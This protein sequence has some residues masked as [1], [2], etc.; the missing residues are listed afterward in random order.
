M[1]IPVTILLLEDSL[2]DAELVTEHLDKSGIT[3]QVRRVETRVDYVRELEQCCP[4]VILSDFSLP[5]FDGPSAFALAQEMCPQVPFLF[6]SGVM[7]EEVAIDSLKRGATDYVLK[8]RLERLGPAVKRALRECRERNQRERAEE[9]LQ[10]NEERLRIALD[11]ARLGAWELD[12][13]T[14]DM[15][16]SPTCM[17]TLG[18]GGEGYL[19]LSRLLAR[20]HPE[21]RDIVSRRTS[22]A[23]DDGEAC[24]V[25]FRIQ[26]HDGTWR[27][28][29]LSGRLVSAG[30]P[31]QRRLAGVVR[32]ITQR[33]QAE[34]D[35][36]NLNR[37][38]EQFI[39]AASHDLRE[40]LRTVRTFTQ[41][42]GRE[43]RT[44]MQPRCNEYL[45][46]VESGAHRMEKLLH[47]L[48]DYSRLREVPVPPSAVDLNLVLREVLMLSQVVIEETN[49]RIHAEPLPVVQGNATHLTQV[50]QNL[51]SNAIK[52]RNSRPPH[53]EISARRQ[54]D[55]FWR[56]TVA[57]NGV[58]FDPKYADYIFGLF[59]RLQTD[60]ASGSGLGLAICKRIIEQGGGRVWA[61]SRPGQGSEFHFTVPAVA[62]RATG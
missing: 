51:I 21:D 58:G 38:L 31:G 62:N 54:P 32:D 6:V 35:L 7:G 41:L 55:G 30:Q 61:E 16:C 28:V 26:W 3:H 36:A 50:L 29:L 2:L 14:G 39:W 34:V 11:A 18:A 44:H 24:D 60:Q 47:D 22:Q 43:C 56:I 42:L 10:R 12:L 19:S 8:S 52:Y 27:W 37:D 9:A 15:E 1:S 13:G 5:T 57:D 46:Y 48:L 4:E 45:D 33:K 25:E 20:V 40:P 49:T 53:I 17:E 23:C 59:K